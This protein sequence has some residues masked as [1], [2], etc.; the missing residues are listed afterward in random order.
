[1]EK[2]TSM[3]WLIVC[4]YNSNTCNVRAV[5]LLQCNNVQ[6]LLIVYFNENNKIHASPFQGRV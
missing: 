2:R 4:K 6:C 5:T 3:N 1:M